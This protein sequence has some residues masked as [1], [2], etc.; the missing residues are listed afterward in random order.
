VDISHVVIDLMAARHE[1]VSALEYQ[2]CDCRS[3]PEFKTGS[4]GSVID[5]GEGES[6]CED[7]SDK[8]SSISLMCPRDRHDGCCALR[9]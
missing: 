1:G 8:A 7:S 3:M 9:E 2:V 5:K 6:S 4:F